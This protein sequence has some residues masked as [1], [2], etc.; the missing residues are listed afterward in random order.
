MINIWWL[1]CK[2]VGH[3]EELYW[4]RNDQRYLVW[5]CRRCNKQ[6]RRLK[7]NHEQRKL[8]RSVKRVY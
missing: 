3:D 7:M 8:F 2:Q 4:D 1:W 5:V 6:T